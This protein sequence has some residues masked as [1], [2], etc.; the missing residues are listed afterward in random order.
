MK[1]D[2]LSEK[3]HWPTLS[4]TDGSELRILRRNES[5]F[6]D[7]CELYTYFELLA[8][9]KVASMHELPLWVS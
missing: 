2:F 8:A 9:T 4:N 5:L 6:Y 1:I 7:D 3:S